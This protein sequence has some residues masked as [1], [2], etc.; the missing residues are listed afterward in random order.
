MSILIIFNLIFAIASYGMFLSSYHRNK[1]YVLFLV[2][3]TINAFAVL[4]AL[5]IYFGLIKKRKDVHMT[6]QELIQEIMS[7]RQLTSHEADV[8]ISLLERQKMI[9]FT[10]QN[11]LA[12]NL[13]SFQVG[14]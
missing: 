14:Y 4:L 2:I 6:R 13:N 9:T 11:Q 8:V 7:L 5:F 3:F 12:C 1:P 10:P